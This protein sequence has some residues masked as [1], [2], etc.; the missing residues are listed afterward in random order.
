MLYYILEIDRDQI[1]SNYVRG[2]YSDCPY[3]RDR[4]DDDDS[5]P[6][7]PPGPRD[8]NIFNDWI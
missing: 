1:S 3:L 5:Y 8:G 4:P 7:D 2:H 6:P